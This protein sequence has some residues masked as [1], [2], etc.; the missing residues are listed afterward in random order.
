MDIHF[1]AADSE[2][3]R[4]FIFEVFSSA[5]ER[6]FVELLSA[7][8]TFDRPFSIFSPLFFDVL[9][10]TTVVTVLFALWSGAA[11]A[12]SIRVAR[13]VPKRVENRNLMKI[14]ANEDRSAATGI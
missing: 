3:I 2:F 12:A 13:L 14:Y 1:R 5:G 4:E 10:I 9:L 8:A 7:V 11:A 6:R